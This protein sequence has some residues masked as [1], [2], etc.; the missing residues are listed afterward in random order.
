MARI[1]V[2]IPSNLVDGMDIKFQAPCDCSAVTG[3][4][5]QYRTEEGKT[6][7]K[8]LTF[9][10]AHGND[11][12]G[13]GNL[14]AQG[15]Y[16]KVIVDAKNGFAYIQNADTNKYLE[17]K[18]RFRPNLLDNSDFTNPVNQR[19]QTEYYGATGYSIDRWR[20]TS[21]LRFTVKSG[22]V[23]VKNE[24][25]GYNGFT[26]YFGDATTLKQGDVYTAAC[27][28]HD[29]TILCG[30]VEITDSEY[31]TAFRMDSG[32][33][34]RFYGS[35]N[36]L[37]VM[38][39]P[40][41]EINIDWIAVYKGEFTSDT[42][43]DYQP[44]GYSA[45][46]MECLRYYQR[47]KMIRPVCSFRTTAKAVVHVPVALPMRVIPTAT[48]GYSEATCIRVNGENFDFDGN[49]LLCEVYTVGINDLSDWYKSIPVSIEF[50]P[51]LAQMTRIYSSGYISEFIIVELSADL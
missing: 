44:K 28:L 17:E 22:Y 35:T 3:L 2:D 47:V 33:T 48:L 12:A 8:N 5:V 18:M 13:L 1:K 6:A 49:D 39:A 16:V 25:T 23:S 31:N 40:G 21:N 4:R 50:S 36:R 43:P 32:T 30:A 27:K 41:D 20:A 34:A 24:G 15:A 26:Q 19:G 9:R 11:L 51:S 42:L 37:I 14:F 29:G 38:M 10:D 45:E 7:T 46:Y